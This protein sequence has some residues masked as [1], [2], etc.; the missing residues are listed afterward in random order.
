MIEQPSVQ[1]PINESVSF[2]YTIASRFGDIVI[3]W[4]AEPES[5]RIQLRRI[6]LSNEKADALERSHHEF[7]QLSSCKENNLPLILRIIIDIV[8]ATCSGI[9]ADRSSVDTILEASSLSAFSRKALS[10]EA[11]IPYGHVSSYRTLAAA[12]KSPLAVRA[13][14]RVLSANPFPLLIP[15][16]RVIGSNGNLAGYQGGLAMKRFLLSMEGIP[17]LSD[18]KVDLVQTPFWTFSE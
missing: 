8:H 12:I 7:G 2:F 13:V 10:L 5:Q 11:R 1:L 16:H 9:P 15:C 14:A 17:F 6:F 3:V 18:N 4:N